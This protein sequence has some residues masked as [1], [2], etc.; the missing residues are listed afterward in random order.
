MTFNSMLHSF[1]DHTLAIAVPGYSHAEVVHSFFIVCTIED[2][3][4][5]GACD[6][7]T[8]HRP[9]IAM[10]ELRVLSYIVAV[11]LLFRQRAGP[12]TPHSA[13]EHP[14]EFLFA[15]AT[16][17][18]RCQTMALPSDTTAKTAVW[19]P[20]SNV[21]GCPWSSPLFVPAVTLLSFPI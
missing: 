8:I 19:V 17:F 4:S 15:V 3:A 2:D 21:M 18:S 11:C 6:W 5:V 13:W 12:S 9:A 1:V 10:S 7:R 14:G 16:V 20:G